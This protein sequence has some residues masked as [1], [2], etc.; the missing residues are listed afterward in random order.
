MFVTL[1]SPEFFGDVSKLRNVNLVAFTQPSLKNVRGASF[2]KSE[3]EDPALQIIVF[4]RI[5]RLFEYFAS[6]SPWREQSEGELFADTLCIVYEKSCWIRETL[7]EILHCLVAEKSEE[8]ERKLTELSGIVK[9][10]TNPSFFPLFLGS[11][12][13]DMENRERCRDW[14][15]YRVRPRKSERVPINAFRLPGTLFGFIAGEFNR[16]K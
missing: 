7:V 5:R 10:L 14:C 1:R 9:L 6:Q 4:R 12:T 16:S 3:L 13:V 8:N 2:G 15:A 11:Q